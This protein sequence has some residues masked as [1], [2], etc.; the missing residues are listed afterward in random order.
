M[1]FPPQR[2]LN[3]SRR[4]GV[5]VYRERAE[6]VNRERASLN[7]WADGLPRLRK[8]CDELYEQAKKAQMD[9]N[10]ERAKRRLEAA[11]AVMKAI[12]EQRRKRGMRGNTRAANVKLG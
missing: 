11:K 1:P 5:P 9:G 10:S 3:Q 2:P 8:R 12:D 6:R 7:A 4:L